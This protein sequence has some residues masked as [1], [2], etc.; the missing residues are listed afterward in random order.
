V[1]AGGSGGAGPLEISISVEM[2][3]QAAEAVQLE[4][5]RLLERAGLRVTAVTVRR[6]PE[7]GPD[8]GDPSAQRA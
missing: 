4:A 6:G 3:R 7:A 2:D 8:S 5:R 1:S